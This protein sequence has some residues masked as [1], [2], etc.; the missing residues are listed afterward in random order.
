MCRTFDLLFP[1]TTRYRQRSGCFY[2]N[3]ARAQ[4]LCQCKQLLIRVGGSVEMR[5]SQHALSKITNSLL[6]LKTRRTACSGYTSIVTFQASFHQALS[7]RLRFCYE[8]SQLLLSQCLES[9]KFQGHAFSILHPQASKY[10]FS[11]SMLTNPQ[12]SSL[13]LLALSKNFITD[14]TL[15]NQDSYCVSS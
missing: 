2:N 8:C 3:R 6:T 13:Q 10:H 1:E 5:N 11:L 12:N 7:Q 9:S 15:I 4:T 14:K